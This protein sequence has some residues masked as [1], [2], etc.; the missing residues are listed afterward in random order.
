MIIYYVIQAV[1]VLLLV[2]LSFLS[3]VTTLPFGID[4]VLYTVGRWILQVQNDLWPLQIVIHMFFYFYLPFLVVLL[5]L[6]FIL[7]HR[8]PG[9]D[10]S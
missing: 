7:G 5:I 1:L 8:A 3:P 6:K 4:G 2:L 10:M 9:R